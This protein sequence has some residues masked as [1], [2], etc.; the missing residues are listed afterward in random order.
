MGCPIE[1]W[2]HKYINVPSKTV[3]E[4]SVGN[5]RKKSCLPHSLS[6]AVKMATIPESTLIIKTPHVACHFIKIAY[7]HIN[8]TSDKR[9]LVQIFYV[10]KDACFVKIYFLTLYCEMFLSYIRKQMDK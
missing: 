1:N 10:T 5:A 4:K 2:L 8:N 3:V 6:D 7:R 9:P